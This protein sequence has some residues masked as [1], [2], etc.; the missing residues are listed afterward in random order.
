MCGIAGFI[1]YKKETNKDTLTL[2]TDVL[3]HRGPDDKGYE[4]YTCEKASVGLGH[5]RL[6]ILDLSSLGHQPMEYGDWSIVFNGEIYNFGEIKIELQEKYS[7]DFKSHA[8]TEVIIHAFDRWGIASVDKFNGMF[9]F[10][11]FNKKTNE[12]YCVRDRAGVKPLYYYQSGEL[13][14]FSSELKSFHQHPK[15][16]KSINPDVL[17]LYFQYGYIPSPYSIFEKVKKVSPGAYLY[18]NLNN[19]T[20]EEKKYW[21]IVEVYNQPKLSINIEDAISETENL[22][23]SAFKY[24]LISDVP[25][26]IFLSG[27][28]DSAAV[29]GLLQSEHSEKLKTFTIGF[30]DNA[31]DEAP[32]A[33]KVAD[34]LGTEHHE[35]YCTEKDALEIIPTLSEIYDEPFADS[36]A[37]PTIL[38]SKIAAKDVTVVLSADGGDEAFGGYTR[39]TSYISNYYKLC[40]IPK[41][42]RTLIS[43]GSFLNLGKSFKNL[44]VINS[45]YNYNQLIE[46]LSGEDRKS[47]V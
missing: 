27:G 34:Y 33:K 20:L 15:F 7:I 23:K 19:N 2:M 46:I 21:D 31:Y 44:G 42:F 30:E 45:K 36:S 41:P 26:G 1:D 13:F 9:A 38:V 32:F 4:V 12:V 6:S 25:V 43:A 16:E 17:G 28:Y 29:A 3:A 10:V 11:I 40:K 35:Y 14:L 18:I 22:L 37:I 8:D 47:V 24:R 5:R 39:Y